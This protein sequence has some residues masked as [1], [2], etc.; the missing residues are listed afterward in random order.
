MSKCILLTVVTAAAA[1]CGGGPPASGTVTVEVKPLQLAPGQKQDVE[2]TLQYT[3]PSNPAA[4]TTV[5]YKAH[6]TPPPGWVIEPASWE[7]SQPMKTTD[8]GFRET[9]KVSVTVP[10]DAAPGEYVVK[11]AV[12]SASGPPQ[13]PDIKFQVLRKDK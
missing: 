5:S 7:H 9:R 8:G 1:G 10:A 6:L 12:S 2:L 11:L 13:S 4:A 3:L